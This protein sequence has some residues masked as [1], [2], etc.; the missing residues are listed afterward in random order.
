MVIAGAPIIYIQQQLGHNDIKTT[1]NYIATLPVSF[2][3]VYVDKF[4]EN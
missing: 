1:M 3:K 2:S 4:F